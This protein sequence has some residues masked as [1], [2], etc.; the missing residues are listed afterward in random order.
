MCT[1]TALN[2]A[3]SAYATFL[4]ATVPDAP[5]AVTVIV[6]PSA[7]YSSVIV[8]FTPG[9]NGC[10]NGGC[11]FASFRV[12]ANSALAMNAQ[13]ACA[14]G[15]L[16]SRMSPLVCTVNNILPYVS[17]TFSVQETTNIDG[18]TSAWSVSSAP[19]SVVSPVT[20]CSFSKASSLLLPDGSF[21]MDWRNYW[22]VMYAP[23]NLAWMFSANIVIGAAGVNT[24]GGWSTWAKDGSY[25]GFLLKSAFMKQQLNGLIIGANYTITWWY[26]KG[27]GFGNNDLCVSIDTNSI[28]Y[29]PAATST[30]WNTASVIFVPTSDSHLLT[31]SS[32]NPTGGNG[33]MLLDKIIIVSPTS[34]YTST[35]ASPSFYLNAPVNVALNITACGCLYVKTPTSSSIT[36]PF[37][38]SPALPSGLSFDTAI[39]SIYGTP[40]VIA[41]TPVVYTVQA[42]NDIGINT[43]YV[44]ISI[45][46]RKTPP[47]N[48]T[49]TGNLANFYNSLVVSWIPA[50]SW[51]NL[52]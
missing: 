46:Y 2:S 14:E 40:T 42:M 36:S 6:N 5:T 19:I 7:L 38:I 12:N 52:S 39:G 44:S 15:S 27:S 9:N 50:P 48:V 30:S 24:N 23:T 21:E 51:Y 37:S 3:K 41:L 16:N 4:T 32:T 10:L 1:Y 43:F 11:T 33:L 18:G 45:V 13:V 29:L 34:S 20:N 35:A 47:A 28:Y 49:V 17:Y 8:S 25:F 26:A 22:S 31:F